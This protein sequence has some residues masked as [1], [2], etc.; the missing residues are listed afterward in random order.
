M[1]VIQ[2]S[3]FQ[4][5]KSKKI[6]KNFFKNFGFSGNGH[7]DSATV[8]ESMP[9]I[10]KEIFVDDTPPK[11]NPEKDLNKNEFMIYLQSNFSSLGFSDGYHNPDD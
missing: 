9:S 8:V 2:N 7:S 3:K 11:V 10:S 6:M 4:L 1:R 5:T